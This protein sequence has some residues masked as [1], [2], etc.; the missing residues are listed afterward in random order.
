[1]K[2]NADKKLLLS[3]T[4]ISIFLGLAVLIYILIRNRNR[5]NSNTMKTSNKGIELIKH[6]EGLHDGNAIANLQPKMD[7]IGIWTIGWGKALYNK[8]T[9][10]QLK[11]KDDY[12]IIESQ[13]PEFL[14]ITEQKADQMLLEDIQKFEIK[15]KKNL[16]VSISQNQFDALVAHTYNTGGSDTLFSLINKN[17]PES[18]IQ[19][20]W[21]T[22][23]ITA[24]GV[25]MTG[26]IRRRKSEYHLFSTGQLKFTF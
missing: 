21:T 14:T 9:G 26:L 19:N 6:F 13:Y 7:P 11:G 5:I 4:A 3:A 18:E 20:W 2:I 17:A 15:V 1:M 8:F 25:Q 23:Y 16:A 24:G 22:R 12:K 10:K